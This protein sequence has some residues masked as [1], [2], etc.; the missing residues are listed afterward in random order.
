MKIVERLEATHKTGYAVANGIRCVICGKANAGKSTLY[1][2][3]LGYEA[4][5]V[6][7]IEG[8][9]RDVLEHTVS[10]GNLTL[11]LFDTAGLRADATDKVELIGIERTRNA[12]GSAELILVVFDSSSALNDEDIALAEEL[13]KGVTPCIAVINKADVKSGSFDEEYVRSC[14][15]HVVEID[16]KSGRIDELRNLAEGLFIDDS[17]DL[18]TDAVIVSSR[19]AAAIESALENLRMAYGA[20]EDGFFEDICAMYIEGALS[21]ISEMDGREISKDIVDG[22]FSK[23][24]VGK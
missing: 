17:I 24:C 4:A 14:F 1:N 23:F 10:M 22:I 6:T 11:R 20:S 7:D 15:E 19:Q 21:A 2:A 16:A 18:G 9:T 12:I 8:T 13:K 5:I 3:L